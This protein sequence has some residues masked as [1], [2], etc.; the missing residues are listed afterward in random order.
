M[1]SN[2]V[3][4]SDVCKVPS[5]YYY[6]D[7]LEARFVNIASKNNPPQRLFS[8]FSSED[9]ISYFN[10]ENKSKFFPNSEIYIYLP[11]F[12]L[13][14]LYE[15]GDF[16]RFKGTTLRHGY[17]AGY[18]INAEFTQNFNQEFSTRHNPSLV[19]MD[20][21]GTILR[22]NFS[23]GLMGITTYQH[24]NVNFKFIR[25]LGVIR[26]KNSTIRF[27]LMSRKYESEGDILRFKIDFQALMD[28]F[29][30][31]DSFGNGKKLFANN[32]E[33]VGEPEELEKINNIS[34]NQTNQTSDLS[35]LMINQYM[36]VWSYL[37]PPEPDTLN[38][39]EQTI[40]SQNT[41]NNTEEVEEEEEEEEEEE[42]G[43]QLPSF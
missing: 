18:M 3:N 40:D 19:A 33:I 37:R 2:F 27:I 11:Y 4:A 36:A 22:E 14:Y 29:R 20:D 34:E 9:N 31:C 5:G 25:A 15:P 23:F 16:M 10:R 21:Q 28:S 26:L 13:N 30:N 35:P 24:N 42:M 41:L 6:D 12:A 1:F 38:D 7:K 8:Y 17:V 39:S 32:I 43:T